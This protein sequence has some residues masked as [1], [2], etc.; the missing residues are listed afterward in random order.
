[1]NLIFSSWPYISGQLHLGRLISSFIPG[2]CYRRLLILNNKKSLH[3]SG[4]D[5]YGEKEIRN[6][7]EVILRNYNIHKEVFKK[8]SIELEEYGKTSNKLFKEYCTKNLLRLKRE[9]TIF[10]KEI[11]YPYCP[12][13]KIERR[14]R[15]T[16]TCPSCLGDLIQN[17]EKR[18]VLLP[19]N[20][21]ENSRVVYEEV[22]R[23][24]ITPGLSSPFNK[25]KKI[26]VWIEALHGYSFLTQNFK[27]SSQTYF[28]GT[29]NEYFHK[30]LL[31]TLLNNN[32]TRTH[33][34]SKYLLRE[35]QKMSGSVGNFITIESFKDEES[36]LRLYLLSLN[37]SK[38]DK[39]FKRSQYE[40][41]KKWVLN[42]LLPV[43]DKEKPLEDSKEESK[44][45]A[46][47]L[48]QIYHKKKSFSFFI[49]ILQQ[50]IKKKENKNYLLITL[51][52]KIL[53][54]NLFS[55]RAL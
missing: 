31:P 20:K 54:P 14:I 28:Y 34:V 44:K 16:K 1:M 23:L 30:S 6:I 40:L 22:E 4:L 39:N 8:L 3:Y 48:L 7:E 42:K 15:G 49:R 17:Y 47:N 52:I 5:C 32:N 29:D 45:I 10:L 38:S 25:D 43:L 26:W 12:K 11:S 37:L 24:S 36:I 51:I 2:D 35:E 13:C 19:L 41:F 50:E 33:Y 27:D 18:L 55:Y 21:K 53:S 46:S 9:G